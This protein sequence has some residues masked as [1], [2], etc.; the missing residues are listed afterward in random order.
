M[1]AGI[2]V[3]LFLV[4]GALF[5]IAG[6]IGRLAKAVEEKGKVDKPTLQV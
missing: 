3:A 2:A 1:D 4:A 6:N 5:Q